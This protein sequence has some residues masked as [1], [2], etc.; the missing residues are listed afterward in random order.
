MTHTETSAPT[1]PR[2][3][4]VGVGVASL[5]VPLNSTMI[6][7]ALRSVAND[8]GIEKAHARQLVLVYLI[9]MLVGQPIAGRI[10]D[11]IGAKRLT[12]I[13]LLGFAGCSLAAVFAGSFG[14]LVTARAA[15][16]AFAAC[17]SPAASSM[18][19]AIVPPGER[20][21]AF[22]IQ[23]SVIGVG[24]AAGP[25]LGGQL[26][27]SF[28]WKAIFLANLPIIAVCLVTLARLPVPRVAAE[29]RLGAAAEP[30]RPLWNAT[31]TAAFAT[32]ALSNF[33]QYMLLLMCPAVLEAQSWDSRSIGRVLTA[34]TAGIILFGP[35]GGRYSDR[36]GRRVPVVGGM[37]LAAAGVA[38]LIPFDGSVSVYA[39]VVA[40]AL[41]GVGFGIA[42]PGLNAAGIEAAPVVRT[43]IG[44]GWLSM[45]R[46]IGSIIST[47]LINAFV[48]DDGRGARTMFIIGTVSVLLAVGT[49]SLVVGRRPSITN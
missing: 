1:V 9:A 23:G 48:D 8:F 33:G 40:L 46:Y 41:F 10:S 49:S 16:A 18:L 28:N 14:V 19:R 27:D 45:S 25:L 36:F 44:A 3:V 29:G 15:Q 11:R 20:G 21:R 22:G 7:V 31:F 38:S 13:S 2:S 30:E 24:V 5:L 6:S 35:L 34:M 32:Q 47:S 43:G 17:L 4:I 42:V 39:L 26:V 37:A 12:I